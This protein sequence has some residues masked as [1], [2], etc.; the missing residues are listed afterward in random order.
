MYRQQRGALANNS[1]S[2]NSG[3]HYSPTTWLLYRQSTTTYY[4][5]EYRPGPYRPPTG[6]RPN[7]PTPGPQRSEYR[8]ANVYP[9]AALASRP[10]SRAS[11]YCSSRPPPSTRSSRPTSGPPPPPHPSGTRRECAGSSSQPTSASARGKSSCQIC[12]FSQKSPEI[13]KAVYHDHFSSKSLRELLGV[14]FSLSGPYF[15]PSCKSHHSPY[16]TERTKMS[17][18]LVRLLRH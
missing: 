7:V 9:Y 13:K 2:T 11:P 15:C 18:Y 5:P 14:E 16:P 12:S 17:P 4:R 1:R 6:P 3:S 10:G 8:R